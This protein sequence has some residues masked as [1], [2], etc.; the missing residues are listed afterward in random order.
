MLALALA[1][2]VGTWTPAAPVAEYATI[3]AADPAVPGRVYAGTGAGLFKSEDGGATW[4]HAG[5]RPSCEDVHALG[6]D[7]S[8]SDVVYAGTNTSIN[9][10]SP[11]GDGLFRSPDAAK[12][13]TAL[14]TGHPVAQLKT[15][16]GVPGRLYVIS[17]RSCTLIH[18]FFVDCDYQLLRSDDFGESFSPAFAGLPGAWAASFDIDERNPLRLWAVAGGVYR[19]DNGGVSWVRL[20]EP[21]GI[22]GNVE[23]A[24]I[25]VDPRN[26][27]RLLVST[28]SGVF[29]SG[30]GGAHWDASAP[31][32][33]LPMT[34]FLFDSVRPGVVYAVVNNG[35]V[36]RSVDD[37]VSW[38]AFDAGL[39]DVHIIF[40]LSEGAPEGRNGQFLY[41]ATGQG[42]FV[43]DLGGPIRPAVPAGP[44]VTPGRP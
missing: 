27:D 12:E 37:G 23:W 22:P 31:A 25:A 36:F 43:I 2:V 29:R 5:S 40:G 13:W 19:S 9:C 4:A 16:P 20:E 10:V 14:E 28:S 26:G 21:D 3:V 6:I 24:S 15:V 42:V 44:A 32:D 18:N 30:D 8:S 35:D 1:A 11:G 38:S 7:A 17:A 33:L 39:E 34:Q 41:A